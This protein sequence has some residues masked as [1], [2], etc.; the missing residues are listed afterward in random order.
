[1]ATSFWVGD[2]QAV[3]QVD[4]LTPAD[5][6]V[7]NTF[8][9]TINGKSITFTATAG[10]VANVTAGLVALLSASDIPEFAEIDWADA[11]TAITA[12]AS[13]AGSGFTLTTSASGGTA[14][15]SRSSTT[16]N[17][18][19]TLWSVAANHSGGSVPTTNDTVWLSNSDND[20]DDG[21]AQSSVTLAAL[22]IEQSFTGDMGRPNSTG[23]YND[24]RTAYLAI[25]ATTVNVGMG[26]GSG[27]QLLRLNT[28]TNA[29]TINVFATGSSSE[30]SYETFLWKGTHASNVVNV[31][32]GSVGI[33]VKP[34]ETATVATLRVGYQSSVDSDANVRLGPGVTLTT[35]DQ[36]GG[37]VICGSSFTTLSIR[38]GTFSTNFAAAGT[39]I[40]LDGGTVVWQSSGNVSTLLVGSGGVFDASQDMRPITVTD[41]TVE[42]GAEIRDPHKRITFTNG[43]ILNRCSLADVKLE[44]GTD[45]TLTIA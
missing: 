21:L 38:G 4:T 14:T 27:S 37:Q 45:I 5:V 30:S 34:G 12:T 22:N 29:T 42:A 15:F 1:M 19:P 24:Y 16:S 18:G 6:G 26:N 36:S 32:R 28:G 33:A 11:T 2:A 3:A 43:I 7:G 40:N 25:S 17:S 13:T 35:V 9:V 20:I 8:T 10:T 31:T 44:I 41:C 23:T 39:T